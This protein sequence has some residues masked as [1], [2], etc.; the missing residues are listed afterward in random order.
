ME[1][2]TVNKMGSILVKHGKGE[3]R[4]P[5]FGCE[6]I[7]TCSVERENVC[8]LYKAIERLAEYEQ[9]AITPEQILEIDKLYQ[10]RLKE[11]EN[12]KQRLVAGEW[13][14]CSESLPEEKI[15]P[16]TNDFYEY[17]VTFKSDEVTDIRHY[18]FGRGHWWNGPG[19]MDKY[20]TAWRPLP[21]PYQPNKCE[22]GEDK[23]E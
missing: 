23:D 6:D 2:L 8:G 17:Q 20:V 21:E 11:I 5:C 14:P 7:G 18:K 13:I 10:Q 19:T 22:E 3:Y 12:L 1:R 15:N 16:V 9:T 4:S